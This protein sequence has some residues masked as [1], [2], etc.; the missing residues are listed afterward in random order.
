VS[1]NPKL[2]EAL[3]E[4]Y[5]KVIPDDVPQWQIF[6]LRLAFYAGASSLLDALVGNLTPGPKSEPPD[7]EMLASVY[8]EFLEFA[9]ELG[10]SAPRRGGR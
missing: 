6:E 4:S 7:V 1:S 8:E 5:R 9:K 10:R 3:W 2:V